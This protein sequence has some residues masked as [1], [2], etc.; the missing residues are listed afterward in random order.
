VI[1]AG[2]NFRIVSVGPRSKRGGTN[3]THG[4]QRFSRLVVV[5]ERGP[6]RTERKSPVPPVITTR[7]S[8]AVSG[9]VLLPEHR[10]R[11]GAACAVFGCR[12]RILL[13]R[14]LEQRDRGP[15]RS[16]VEATVRVRVAIDFLLQDPEVTEVTYAK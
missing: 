12:L 15:L 6:L 3:A 8:P 2:E 7:D 13:N 14:H 9:Q 10:A 16:S 1:G 5:L 4:S 11:R